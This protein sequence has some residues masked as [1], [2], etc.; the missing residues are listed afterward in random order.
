MV[1]IMVLIAGVVLTMVLIEDVLTLLL[2]VLICSPVPCRAGIL[3]A[4]A[5]EDDAKM[6]HHQWYLATQY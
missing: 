6:E 2:M 5:A 3:S 4:A 1:L